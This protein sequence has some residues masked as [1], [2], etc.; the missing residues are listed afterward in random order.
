MSDINPQVVVD[1]IHPNLKLLSHSS[2]VLLHKCPRKYELYKLLGKDNE[3][4]IDTAF[5]TSVGNGIQEYM[6]S[7]SRVNAYM[8]AYKGWSLDLFEEGEERKKKSFWHS[9]YAIDKFIQQYNENELKDYE[10]VYIDS[11]DKEGMPYRQ[12]ATELGFDIDIGDGFHYRGFLDALLLDKQRNEFIVYEGKT[13]ATRVAEATYRNSAQQIGYSVIVDAVA[14]RLGINTGSSYRVLTN[15][16]K[17]SSFE[18]ELLTFQ[19]SYVSRALWIKNI[20]LDV[21]HIIEYSEEGYFP[22]HGEACYDFF[23][24][25]SHFGVCEMSNKVLTGGAVIPEKVESMD[26]YMFKFS[27]D[28]LI[29]AQLSS[30]T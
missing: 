1:G 15:V 30:R 7:H 5:G 9:L 4:S 8:E 17:S 20:L 16:Y 27:L 12:A 24:E 28:E 2:S 13:T 19:K 14:K 23:R 29:E 22:M 11:L 3:Q 18:W 10:L 26:K 6:H 25:C 21:K